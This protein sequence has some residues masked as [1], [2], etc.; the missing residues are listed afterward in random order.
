M[1]VA[2]IF[3]SLFTVGNA[4]KI[5]AHPLEYGDCTLETRRALATFLTPHYQYTVIPERLFLTAGV[6]D[7]L[8]VLATALRGRQAQLLGLPHSLNSLIGSQREHYVALVEDPAY[9]L[10]FDIFR[11]HGRSVFL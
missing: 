8:D 6:S 5:Q 1:N 3:A 11:N 2:D 10:V 7:G 9:F 4:G